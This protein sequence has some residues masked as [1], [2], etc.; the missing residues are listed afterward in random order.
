MPENQSIYNPAFSLRQLLHQHKNIKYLSGLLVTHF[1]HSAEKV[2]IEAR[3][4]KTNEIKTFCAK[5]LLIGAGAI[6]TSR[7][8]LQSYPSSERNPL[9]IVDNKI[10]F[11]PF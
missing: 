2:E 4:I 10:S 3:D 9:P 1:R 8:V 5:H 6:N 7:I 11:T